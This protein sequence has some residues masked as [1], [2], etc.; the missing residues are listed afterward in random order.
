VNQK[1][2]F[3][4]KLQIKDLNRKAVFGL[5]ALLLL[6]VLGNYFRWSFFFH[7]DFLFGTIAVWLVLCLYGLRW[8]AIAAILSAICTYFLW[9]HPYAIIIF[10]CEYLF[11]GILYRRYRQN[12]VLL[13]GIYWVCIGMPLV[14]LFYGQVLGVDPMQV[15]IIMLKQAVNGIFNALVASLLLTYTPIHRWISRPQA[16]S[17]LSLQQ[18]LLN[19]LVAFVF[20]PVL[21]LMALDS[22]R[23]VDN[24]AAEQTLQLDTVS[25]NLISQIQNWQQQHLQAVTVL[26]EAT[27]AVAAEADGSLSPN[28]QNLQPLQQ[29]ATTL[30]ALLPDLQSL[31][32]V[33]A[34]DDLLVFASDESRQNPPLRLPAN[35]ALSATAL[36]EASGN[37]KPILLP[38]HL[39]LQPSPPASVLLGQPILNQGQLQG[40]V[41]SE[42]DLTPLQEMLQ[43][44]AR[45]LLYQATLVDQQQSVIVSTDP[46]LPWGTFF[47]RRQTGEVFPI[48]ARTYQWF[49]TDG[50][51]LFMVR[52][53]HSLFV[54]ESPLQDLGNWLLVLESPAEPYMQVVQKEHIESL[55]I[56][57]V[58]AGLAL[59]LATWLS[60]RLVTP[61]FELANI[62]TNLPTQ[63]LERKV[64]QWPTSPVIELR[65]L[66]HNFQYMAATLTQKFQ[67]LQ[68]AKQNAE[69]ANQAKSEF[70]ANMSHELRTPLHAI[71]GFTELLHRAPALETHHTELTLIQ[72]S[73]EHLLDLI[74]DVLDVAKIEAGH[75]HLHETAFNLQELVMTLEEMFRLRAEA[76]QIH[77]T[78][79]Y[80]ADAP[81]W[82]QADQRKLRQVLI[83]LLSNAIKFTEV[84][85]VVLRISKP[86]RNLLSRF[87]C[88]L[89]FEV[90]DTGPGIAP[91]ELG[92]LFQ[93]FSQTQAG[94][95]S[96]EGTGLGLHISDQFV[97]LMGGS[98]EVMSRV[99]Q[100]TR[101]WFSIPVQ[102][103]AALPAQSKPKS[104]PV[105]GL[106]P[107]QPEYRLLIVDDQASN[108]LLLVKW[109]TSL[110]FQVREAGNGKEAIE[111]WQD[112]CPHLIWMDMRMPVMDGYEATRQIKLQMKGQATAIIALT[113]SVFEEEKSLV[114]SAGCDD[115]VR[116]PFQ[117]QEIVDKLTKHLG[118]Q[119]C[120]AD[121][122]ASE[123]QVNK[124]MVVA[125]LPQDSLDQMPKDWIDQV[126]KAATQ[127]DQQT[128]LQLLTD[129]PSEQAHISQSLENWIV[130]F[131]FD[132][133]MTLIRGHNDQED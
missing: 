26:A 22:H 68:R 6:A 31:V 99:G 12:L 109:L 59:A 33:N 14:W 39:G 18:T 123:T 13:N 15:Q 78:V 41:W 95:A 38:G 47:N 71:L 81:Q 55:L 23:V 69:V 102:E 118:V 133:I 72:H 132:K 74:N 54:R 113:A 119:F 30:Q 93:A 44:T 29:Q 20:F 73:G 10:V 83:N 91:E 9:N 28:F 128:L 49:P 82:I 120:Y 77:L 3:L 25:L 32:V 121:S 127:A 100:G 4:S 96:H 101:F 11:V 125:D 64:I 67:E 104:P 112:W 94:R 61:L 80:A 122:A 36:E 130:N 129:I 60:R 114:L 8:G 46:D 45:D 131:R 87:Q 27:A 19:I 16:L 56:L 24:I 79:L 88:W 76:K 98:I 2:N 111:M 107:D 115:F 52:W 65:S 84:G 21:F 110:G 35:D 40:W 57:M 50:S 42:I 117:Q 34:T 43:E 1:T 105:V 108:R 116:K 85:Q 90:E 63:V 126:Y 7:I 48:D 66:V 58:V 103:V 70:L 86:D 53:R 92:L 75:I 124:A 97:K 37:L 5:V 106:A 51:P 62:T 89:Q 17:A